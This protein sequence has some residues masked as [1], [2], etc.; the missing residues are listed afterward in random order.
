[1]LL[2]PQARANG[3]LATVTHPALGPV[4]ALATPVRLMDTPGRL[5]APPPGLGEHT[6]AVLAEAGYSSEEI[7]RLRGAGVVR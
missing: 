7:A 4:R 2:D 1:M 3:T 5:P 6:D